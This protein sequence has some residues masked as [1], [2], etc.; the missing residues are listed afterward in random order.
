M[1]LGS[2]RASGTLL[3]QLEA[4][5]SKFSFNLLDSPTADKEIPPEFCFHGQ[6]TDLDQPRVGTS[7]AG[8]EEAKRLVT[9]GPNFGRRYVWAT[10]CNRNRRELFSFFCPPSSLLSSPTS[11]STV[12][13]QTLH[14]TPYSINSIL[15]E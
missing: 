13:S 5:F 15:I 2:R 10:A 8:P 3:G 1:L 14:P 7:T 9:L 4:V 12:L 6:S 11:F